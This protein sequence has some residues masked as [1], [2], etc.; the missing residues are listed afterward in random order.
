MTFFFDD[1]AFGLDEDVLSPFRMEL[2]DFSELHFAGMSSIDIAE[3]EG[4]DALLDTIGDDVFELIHG[5][6][7][8]P[9][10]SEND[11]TSLHV[12][13]LLFWFLPELLE[14]LDHS[15]C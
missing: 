5:D 4:I 6:M 12:F 1:S 7:V 15:V 10:Q 13:L 9:H 2:H 8:K 3:V 11:F 14:V